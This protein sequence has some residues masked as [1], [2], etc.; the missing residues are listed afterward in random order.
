MK[1]KETTITFRT[2]VELK[3]KLQ[4]MAEKEQRTLSNMIELLLKKATDK[5]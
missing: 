1:E 5:K 3:E 2:T 4:A